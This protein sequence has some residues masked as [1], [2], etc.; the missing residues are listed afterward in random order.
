MFILQEETFLQQGKCIDELT[1][2]VSGLLPEHLTMYCLKQN[3]I[4]RTSLY[5]YVTNKGK[6]IRYTTTIKLSVYLPC[7]K[8]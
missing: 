3:T 8:I 6:D 4:T 7:T 5:I 1:Q 2:I